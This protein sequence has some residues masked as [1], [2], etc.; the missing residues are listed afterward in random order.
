M[1]NYALGAPDHGVYVFVIEGK[2]RVA[3]EVLGRRDGMRVE[4]V[5]QLALQ[6]IE[7]CDVLLIEVPMQGT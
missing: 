7:P 3:G 6:G 4:E 2:V 5:N 1:V